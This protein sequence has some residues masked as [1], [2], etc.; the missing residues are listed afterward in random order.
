MDCLLLEL[1]KYRIVLFGLCYWTVARENSVEHW[2]SRPSE[3]V[4]PRR[5]QQRLTQATSRE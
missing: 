5:D 4:S 2:F 1:I 3:H